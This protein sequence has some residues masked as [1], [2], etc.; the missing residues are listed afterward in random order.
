MELTKEQFVEII[1]AL[2]AQTQR[3]SE[4]ASALD[5][6]AKDGDNHKLVF[7]TPLVEAIVKAIDYDGAISWWMWDG[8]NWGEKAEEFTAYI[9]DVDDDNREM[10]VIRTAG[11]LYDY[12]QRIK[13]L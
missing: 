6:A 10:W 13:K 8:P 2:R 1:E 9:G 7:N 12:I 5:E 11:D 4:I 3:D